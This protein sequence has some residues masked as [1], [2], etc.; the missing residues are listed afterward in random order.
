MTQFVPPQ[1][2]DMCQSGRHEGAAAKLVPFL[3]VGLGEGS[4]AEG[5]TGAGRP[6]HGSGFSVA[7][8]CPRRPWL[9]IPASSA[10]LPQNLPDNQG[11]A[12]TPCLPLAWPLG[13]IPR[14]ARLGSGKLVRP[15][16]QRGCHCHTIRHS[17]CPHWL[18]VRV[19]RGACL[20]RPR[21]GARLTRSGW[22]PGA[23]I[24]KLQR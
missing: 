22:G 21:P 4:M 19:T 7:F 11:S 16:T 18:C 24:P 2:W 8:N 5:A 13:S 9:C 3:T 23:C 20:E 15:V 12:H 1:P 10:S 14:G 6:G 17:D